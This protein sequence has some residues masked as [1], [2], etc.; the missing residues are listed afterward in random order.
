MKNNNK[1]W[2]LRLWLVKK[3]L[4]NKTNKE[5]MYSIISEFF[6][7]HDE[8]GISLNNQKEINENNENELL[9]GEFMPPVNLKF[10]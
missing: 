10:Q 6:N 7:K 8:E 5:E 9:M 1:N 4:N 3:L 2:S